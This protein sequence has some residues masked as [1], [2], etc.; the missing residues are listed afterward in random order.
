MA[1]VT[2]I[3]GE[4]QSQVM[5]ALWRL[6]EGSVEQVRAELPR[7]HQGAYT[8]V[9]TTLNRLAERGLLTR[10]RVGREIIYRPK[11]DEA[12]YLLRALQHTLSGASDEARTA[13]LAQ[14]VGHLSE[15]E[16]G[17]LERL[18]KDVEDARRKRR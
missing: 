8:T 10:T 17:T 1:S 18:A 12:Q 6:G 16:R 13:A 4:L 15:G 14:L 11:F 2:P 7:R 3:Q 9:Q 5:S